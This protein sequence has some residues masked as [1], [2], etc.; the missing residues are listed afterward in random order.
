MDSDDKKITQ[1]TAAVPYASDVVPFVSLPT[2]NPETKKTTIQ[3]MLNGWIEVYDTWAY[4]SATTITVP[5]GATSIYGSGFKIRWKQGGSYKYAYIVT[6][7]STLLTITG[8]SDYSVANSA[9]TDVAYSI[10]SNPIGFPDYFN[11]SP[12]IV[13]F[14]SNPANGVYRFRVVGK[15]CDLTISQPSNGTSNATNFTLTLPITCATISN[16]VAVAV[17]G[18]ITNN[19][20]DAN[21]GAGFILSAGTTL[22]LYRDQLGTAWT[23]TNGKRFSSLQISYEIA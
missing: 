4:A 11:W 12:T 14:S 2:V 7:A 20:T 16:Y 5:S 18:F 15:R 21:G 10:A 17:G 3:N 13:G 22:I 6:V 19:G 8:G 9:I 1:L 23:N